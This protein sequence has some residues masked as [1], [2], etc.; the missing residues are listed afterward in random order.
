MAHRRST[1]LTSLASAET[2]SATSSASALEDQYFAP[3]FWESDY[4][5]PLD[6]I[7]P[8]YPDIP[9]DSDPLFQD[10]YVA[11]ASSTPYHSTSLPR[12]GGSAQARIQPPPLDQGYRTAVPFAS[13]SH[14]SRG[15][16]APH[17]RMASNT[18][19]DVTPEGSFHTA[20]QRPLSEQRSFA[21]QDRPPLKIGRAHV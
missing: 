3:M 11:D 9:S 6:L 15:R 10:I 19:P 20:P 21:W 14:V 18:S 8:T 12:L 5:S 1:S 17:T 16:D 2:Y 7:S 13:T 4:W